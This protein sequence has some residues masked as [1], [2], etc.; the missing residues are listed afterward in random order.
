MHLKP[1]LK[2]DNI[3]LNMYQDD[4]SE[5]SAGPVESQYQLLENTAT[6]CH[7]CGM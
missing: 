6:R 7:G 1:P 4:L 5:P 2:S 3:K